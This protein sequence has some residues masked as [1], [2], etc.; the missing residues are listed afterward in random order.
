MCGLGYT[1]TLSDHD[2]LFLFVYQVNYVFTAKAMDPQGRHALQQR[3]NEPLPVLT[4]VLTQRLI[5]MSASVIQV[6]LL[7][8]SCSLLCKC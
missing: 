7:I 4:Q 5:K 1:A 6:L 2:Y 8:S 3:H